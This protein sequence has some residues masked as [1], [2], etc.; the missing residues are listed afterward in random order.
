MPSTQQ[1]NIPFE[2]ACSEGSY[3]KPLLELENQRGLSEEQVSE[4]LER[5]RLRDAIGKLSEQDRREL[6][7]TMVAEIAE[8]HELPGGF[9]EQLLDAMLRAMIA[10]KRSERGTRRSS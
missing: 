8:G 6:A 2:R 5:A 9:D 10:G 7:E 1:K 4:A 3:V